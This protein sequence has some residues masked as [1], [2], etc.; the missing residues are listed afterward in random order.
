MDPRCGG[1]GA[2][3]GGVWAGRS[4]SLHDPPDAGGSGEGRRGRVAVSLP[5]TPGSATPAARFL[6]RGRRARGPSRPRRRSP[7]RGHGAAARGGSG[8][9]P[10]E[11]RQALRAETSGERRPAGTRSRPDGGPARVHAPPAGGRRPR[12]RPELEGR[13]G[14]RRSRHRLL[15][16]ARR[17]RRPP[18]A[19]SPDPGG[20]RPGARGAHP[21]GSVARVRGPRSQ[22]RGA[23]SL[24]GRRLGGSPRLADGRA[25]RRPLRGWR[26]P[27]GAGLADDRR[28][29]LRRADRPRG[30]DAIVYGRGGGKRGQLLGDD[31]RLAHRGIAGHAIRRDLLLELPRAV[32]PG[33]PPARVRPPVLRRD[34]VHGP[35]RGRGLVLELR[36]ARLLHDRERRELLELRSA[37][38]PGFR[39][40]QRGPG[41]RSAHDRVGGP[42]PMGPARTWSS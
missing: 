35:G 10:G 22:P 14:R 4:A 23:R 21:R 9:V 3:S 41:P 13:R 42:A 37:R 2:R 29:P 40:P 30:P 8:S 15:G 39:L 25:R 11:A 33:G 34:G 27:V 16:P 38:V 12:H 6:P 1:R 7:E 18:L 19:P 36:R 28:R 31:P 26:G 20:G 32:L 24:A 17:R 5:G